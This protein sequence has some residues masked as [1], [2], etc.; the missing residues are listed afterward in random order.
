MA[1][2]SFFH[3]ARTDCHNVCGDQR[4]ERVL[5][6]WAYDVDH[7]IPTCQDFESKLIKLVWEGR[8]AFLSCGS[9]FASDK[10]E[11]SS[12]GITVDDK[13][14]AAIVERKVESSRRLADDAGSKK[15]R[16]CNW[17]L[18]YFRSKRH[19]DV[20]RA[21]STERPVRLLAALYAGVALGL[22]ICECHREQNEGVC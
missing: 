18:G 9:S 11:K 2:S 21:H 5:V 4:D 6:V 14:A 17:G 16:G 3:R 8:S 7:I 19:A 13:E 15:D 10:S 20:E 22:S 12:L 1:C